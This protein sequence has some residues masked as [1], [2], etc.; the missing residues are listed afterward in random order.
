MGGNG[1]V[2]SHSRTSLIQITDLTVGVLSVPLTG[3]MIF[4]YFNLSRRRVAVHKPKFH[5]ARLDTT[6]TRHVRR[7]E[8]VELVVSSVSRRDVTSQ[9][10]LGL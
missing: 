5:L 8:P 10:E 9:V 6:R 4:S 2:E 7:V 1:N 3:S